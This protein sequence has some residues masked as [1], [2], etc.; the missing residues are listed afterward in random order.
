[1]VTVADLARYR[2]DAEMDAS[3]GALDGLCGACA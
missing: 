3:F 2:L 1:M